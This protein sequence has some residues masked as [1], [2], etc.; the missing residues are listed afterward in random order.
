MHY[1]K[2]HSEYTK[3]ER[4]ARLPLY[5][6]R[7]RTNDRLELQIR[8]VRGIH[9]CIKLPIRRCVCCLPIRHRIV[10]KAIDFVPTTIEAS[11][12]EHSVANTSDD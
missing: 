12:V 5:G 11:Q 6:A 7:R 1:H 2:K 8:A 3:N 4:D 9:I 10:S